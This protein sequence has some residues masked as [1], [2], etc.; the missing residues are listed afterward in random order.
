[1]PLGHERH[2]RRQPFL[3]IRPLLCLALIGLTSTACIGGSSTPQLSGTSA[4]HP[5]AGHHLMATVTGRAWTRDCGGPVGEAGCGPANYRG[6]LVF[7]RSMSEEGICPA[8]KVDARG[9][10]RIAL[11]R[12]GR[13]ALIPAPGNGNVVV[14]K[15]RWVS[16]HLGRT[17]VVNILGGNLMK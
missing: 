12:A 1:M 5:I 10:F 14:V 16:V 9:R 17:T 11:P 3:L 13:W 8:A 6:E 2:A 4:A 15:P 7:C